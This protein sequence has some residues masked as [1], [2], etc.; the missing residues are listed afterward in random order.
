MNITLYSV[1]DDPNTLN[2]T[3]GTGSQRNGTPYEPVND[4][5]GYVILDYTEDIEN[6]N[7]CAVTIGN[8]TKYYTITSKSMEIGGNVKLNLSCDVLMTYQ[9][10]INN[11]SG[12]LSRTAT[13]DFTN[14]YLQDNR[15]QYQ[16]DRT[17]INVTLAELAYEGFIVLG[18]IGCDAP[19]LDMIMESQRRDGYEIYHKQG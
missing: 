4:L 10:E 13:N 11:I 8:K 6:Y 2:K 15:A 17:T 5:S 16:A 7:Y 18:V 1:S 9:S 19:S 12:I 14:A 3:L